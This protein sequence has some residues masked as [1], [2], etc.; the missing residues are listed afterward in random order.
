MFSRSQ[1]NILSLASLLKATRDTKARLL[2]KG[3]FAILLNNLLDYFIGE[4]IYFLY[5]RLG[6][7]ESNESK[8]LSFIMKKA[9]IKGNLAF[10][11]GSCNGAYAIWLSKNFSHVIAFEPE[12]KNYNV[13]R[14]KLRLLKKHNIETLR[15]AVSDS[16]RLGKLFIDETIFGHSLLNNSGDSQ[17]KLI[18]VVSLENFVECPVDLVKVDVQG[19]AFDVVKGASGVMD[20]IKRW[21]IELEFNELERKGELEALL[22]SFNYHVSW[23]SE[24]HLFAFK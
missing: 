21:I 7:I 13:I 24:Q 4:R 8:V 19:A 1:L 3:T 6:L 22:K 20:K 16:N 12:E 9:Q 11:I 2:T 18:K 5:P 17:Y 23:L 10:D 15:L 14:L